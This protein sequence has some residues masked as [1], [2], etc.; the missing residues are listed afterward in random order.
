MPPDTGDH[1]FSTPLF[2]NIPAD[3]T[4]AEARISRSDG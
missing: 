4:E 2:T 3:M 1:H